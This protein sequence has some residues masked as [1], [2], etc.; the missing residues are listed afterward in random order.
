MQKVIVLSKGKEFVVLRRA[1]KL[2]VCHECGQAIPKGVFYVEDHI[3]YLR[4]SHYDRVWK[5]WV[6]NKI[7]LLCWKGPLP[8]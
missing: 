8:K 6:T 4:R 2:H 1:R 7:C 5:K 3:N